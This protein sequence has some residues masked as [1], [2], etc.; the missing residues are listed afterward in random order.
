MKKL[1]IIPALL[2]L[3]LFTIYHYKVEEKKVYEQPK[4]IKKI[5]Q[6]IFTN[7]TKTYT[8]K[9]ENN[10]SEEKIFTVETI[11]EIN[12]TK[13]SE[14]T[15]SAKV[16][17]ATNVEECNFFWYEEGELIGMGSPLEKSFSKGKHLLTVV[18]KDTEGH[19][20]NATVTVTAWDYRKVEVLHFNAN[21]G[22]LEYKELTI[23][24][25]KGRYLIMK[26]GTFSKY[27][28]VYDEE[29]NRVE[30]RVIYYNYP[31]ESR[32]DLYTFDENHNQL[33]F[34]AIEITTGQ[35]IY[36]NVK[37][38]DEEGNVTSSKSGENEDEL[39]DD[40]IEHNRE[41]VNY[42]PTS[43]TKINDKTILDE[44]DNIIYEERDYG[45]TKEITKH[46]Y[47]DNNKMT[48][49]ISTTISDENR[50]ETYIYNYDE[51][52][53]L[54]N[55]EHIYKIDDTIACH[56]RTSSTYNKNGQK[57]TEKREMLDGVCL[58]YAEDSFKKFSYDKDGRVKNVTTST[59]EASDNNQTT[60]KIIKSYTNE[61]EE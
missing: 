36:Y 58:E 37:T 41:Y 49:Y 5:E 50:E 17:N 14:I 18:A 16:L 47:D 21:Y 46:I 31:S 39:Y 61:L 1:L 27:I 35:T 10:K 25:H 53:T 44:H 20:S 38:Y 3:T 51:N 30:H 2:S 24:D 33:T 42:N 15:L 43:T 22:E 9:D 60:L 13:E 52:Q 55:M 32:Q 4:V 26:N 7:Y 8:I 23:Y 28:N 12:T 56:D 57:K 19:E 40:Y 45:H 59:D 48:Q 6:Q 54:L 29:D 11:A 34:T